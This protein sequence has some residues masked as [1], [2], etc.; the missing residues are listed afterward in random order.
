MYFS[1]LYFIVTDFIIASRLIVISL[2]FI[3]VLYCTF[4]L[5][6]IV[7]YCN[8]LYN[9][10]ALLYFV[11]FYKCTLLYFIILSICMP[12]VFHNIFPYN[13][14]GNMVVYFLSIVIMWVLGTLI[15]YIE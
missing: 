4:E 5:Y 2:P 10:T 13:N 9:N 11:T 6:S 15:L 3:I 12:V 8:V 14:D 1:S 7:L